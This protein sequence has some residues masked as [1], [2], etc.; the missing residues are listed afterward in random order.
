MLHVLTT[1]SSYGCYFCIH[2]GNGSGEFPA[3][4]RQA[5][6]KDPSRYE[7]LE[8]PRPILGFDGSVSRQETRYLNAAGLSLAFVA[9]RVS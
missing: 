2:E 3:P 4:G 5:R 7:H 1:W 6:G 9:P 8:D